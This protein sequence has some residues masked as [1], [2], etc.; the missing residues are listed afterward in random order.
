[1]RNPMP[2]TNPN[3]ARMAGLSHPCSTE[4]LKRKT[5][6]S[7]NAMPAIHEKTRMP[8]RLSQS[9]PARGWAAAVAGGVAGGGGGGGGWAPNGFGGGGGAD[10]SEAVTTTG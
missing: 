10:G 1:M 4:Y 6:M 9:I 2:V 3:A 7:T 5:A 8:R